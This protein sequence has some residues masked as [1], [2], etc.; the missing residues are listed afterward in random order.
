[1]NKDD[2]RRLALKMEIIS[3]LAALTAAGAFQPR[4]ADPPA[5]PASDPSSRHRR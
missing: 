2:G 1:M 3:S 4:K 5:A